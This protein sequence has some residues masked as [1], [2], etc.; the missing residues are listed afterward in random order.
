[1]NFI[2]T[3]VIVLGGIALI[4]ALILY[5]CSKKFA[6][7]EDPRIGQVTATL[8]GANCG[9][10]GFAGCSGLA[11]ALVKAADAGSLEGLSCPV[12]GAEVMGKVADLLGM[13][14]ANSDPKVAVVRCNGTCALRPRIAEYNGLRTCSAMNATGAGETA[15]GFG[16]L[17][18]GDC[19][20]ACQFDAIHMNPETGLPEVDEE[21]CTSCREG[22]QVR[23]NHHHEQ[24]QLHRLQ[25]VSVV[26]E[27]RGG[28]SYEGYPCS[29]LPGTEAQGGGSEGST[30]SES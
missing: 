18:C 4:A 14:I 6:V 22:V 11:S 25:Q 13:A 12:G 15:C 1:M 10:C 20:A 29:E 5:F 30:N 19:V 2:L 9:G 27:V 21:K 23:G 3:A 24:S 26:Q 16:C 7:Q 28:M 8:P 17:G